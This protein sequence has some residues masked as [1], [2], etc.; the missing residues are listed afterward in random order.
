MKTGSNA[1]KLNLLTNTGTQ[2]EKAV[3]GYDFREDGEE[4]C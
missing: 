3:C 4:L 1:C 2:N